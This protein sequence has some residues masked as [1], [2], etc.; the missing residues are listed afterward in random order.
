M[1]LL[2]DETTD[3]ARIKQL[4]ICAHYLGKGSNQVEEVFW[5]FVPVHDQS[6]RNLAKE[7]VSIGI[8][9]NNLRGQGRGTMAPVRL[10]GKQ[11][12]YRPPFARSIRLRCTRI[13]A[14]TF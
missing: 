1:K 10:P 12:G 14:A 2:D 4:T 13:V 7:I 6:S 11:M 8:D 3:V 9:M 5:G